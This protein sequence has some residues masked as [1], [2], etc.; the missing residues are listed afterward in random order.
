MTLGNRVFSHDDMTLAALERRI[1]APLFDFGVQNSLCIF[2][3]M[4]A[5]AA[6]ARFNGNER[7]LI[8]GVHYGWVMAVDAT[9]FLVHFK[10][11]LV[12]TGASSRPLSQ[13]K[14]ILDAHR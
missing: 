9:E 3:D 11:M 2:F 13:H 14:P 1:L 5:A 12:T 10:F 4:T 7:L 6:A 8:D